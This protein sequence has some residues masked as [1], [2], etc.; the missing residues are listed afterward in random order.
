MHDRVGLPVLV[1]NC[2]MLEISAKCTCLVAG[3]WPC[4]YCQTLRRF[5]GTGKMFLK[6]RQYCCMSWVEKSFCSE[7]LQ[8]IAIAAS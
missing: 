7:C 5:V 1:K 2:F 8:T 3:E 4:I 6:V